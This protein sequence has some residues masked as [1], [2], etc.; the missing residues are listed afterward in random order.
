MTFVMGPNAPDAPP[1]TPGR[2]VGGVRVSSPPMVVGYSASVAVEVNNVNKKQMLVTIFAS[3]PQFALRSIPAR[4]KA[5]PSSARQPEAGTLRRSGEPGMHGGSTQ[6]A[7]FQSFECEDL[8]MNKTLKTAIAALAACGFVLAA[9]AA[10][11]LDVKEH[12][13]KFATSNVEGNPQVDGLQKFADLLKEKSGGKMGG[14]VYTGATLGKDIQ[15]LSSMQGGTVDFATMNTNLLVGVAPDAGLVDLPYLFDSEAEAHAVLDSPVGAKIHAELEPKG[16]LGLSYFDMGYYSLHNS[17][18]PIKS[19]EDM[20]GLKMRVTETPVTIDTFKSWGASAV[21]L[22]YA[23]LYNALEQGV[24]D[25][26]GQPPLNMIYGK[27]G[28]VSKYY[29]VNRYSFT[30]QSLL[31]S[32]KTWEKLTADEKKIVTDAA[33][34]AAIFERQVALKKSQD[35]LAELKKTKTQVIEL[36]PAEIARFRDANKPVTEKYLKVYDA[37][38][39]KELFAEIA[40]YRAAKK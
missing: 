32:K 27:I 4:G 8:T 28:E 40:K 21:P 26:G 12:N 16:L 33:R 24:V 13:F 19:P 18:R 23:E 22:P 38:L 31:M 2:L 15:V 7:V 34:E 9:T 10:N 37:A 35:T 11:A 6:P 29:T 3:G 1:C 25:G 5:D 20:K 17:K 30:P 39:G 36:T 14:K